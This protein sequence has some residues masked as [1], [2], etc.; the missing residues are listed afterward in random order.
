MLM[1]AGLG[2]R[3][4]PFTELEPKALLPL[5]GVPMAQF[6]LDAASAAG[7]D[8]V[9]A[10]V[11]H[12]ADRAGSGLR[13]LELGGAA[14]ELSDESGELLGSAGGLRQA[15]P[16]FRAGEPF[17][18]LNADVLCDVDLA[19]L[20]RAHRRLR[21]RHGARITLTVFERPPLEPGETQ[22]EAYREILLDPTTGLITGL[23]E[24]AVG[25]PYFV[26]AAVIEPE[27][28]AEIPPNGPAEFVPSILLPAIRDGKA[29]AYFTQGRWHDVGS[30]ALWL[31]THVALLRALETGR[32]PRPWRTR[33]ESGNR[34]IAPETWVSLRAPGRLIR[35]AR[36]SG[37]AYW[38][39]LHDQT[40]LPPESL[41]PGA[42]LYGTAQGI[43]QG[44]TLSD[45]IGF[46]GLWSSLQPS[47]RPE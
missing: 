6:A 26:G 38:N 22:R 40:A 27:A 18:V 17:F 11:H 10:N 30:P 20:A 37:P 43:A 31:Q 34:R 42:V 12:L 36:W 45:G 47:S 29:G 2:T 4:R 25:R 32:L 1:A 9:V 15:A 41:G 8:R 5:L 19:A 33:L 24:K 35:T 21:E 13:A 46:R 23:G 7:V 14:L 3:L 28:L 44:G 39:P 16:K